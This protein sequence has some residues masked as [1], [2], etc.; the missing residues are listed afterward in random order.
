MKAFLEKDADYRLLRLHELLREA[1]AND[2]G[3]LPTGKCATCGRDMPD[4]EPAHA[5]IESRCGCRDGKHY[6]RST[7]T[8]YC[9]DCG[10][11]KAL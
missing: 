6:C 7:T 11:P 3:P 10:V 8:L 5:I 1:R 2:P 4:D 9:R